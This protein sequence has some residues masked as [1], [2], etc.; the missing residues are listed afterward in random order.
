M[1][2]VLASPRPTVV[3]GQGAPFGDFEAVGVI[4]VDEGHAV[5]RDDVEQAAE[6]EFDLVERVVDVRVVELDV[7]DDD[8]LGQVVE[9]LRALVEEGGVV[10]VAFEHVEFGV[11]EDARRSRGFSGVRRS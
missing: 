6:G 8:A 1:R 4:A 11:G 3:T 10:F 2:S 7:V 9:E 5:A